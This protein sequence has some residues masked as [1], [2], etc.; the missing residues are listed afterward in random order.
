MSTLNVVK[1]ANARE[2]RFNIDVLA[3]HNNVE[4]LANQAIAFQANMAVIANADK[5]ADLCVALSGHDIEI[6]AGAAGLCEAAARPCH[7]S[8]AAIVGIAGLPS[9]LAAVQAGNDVALANKE[10]L[11]CA[12]DLLKAEALKSGA[13]IL[14]MDSEHS[15][16]FQVLQDRGD[17]EKLTLTASGG[18]FLDTPLDQ[19]AT[20]S[21]SEAMAHPRWSMGQKISIDSATMMNKALEIMEAAFLF[22]KKADEIDVVIHPQSIIHSLVHYQDGSVLAQLGEP[23]MQSPIAYALSWPD[24]RLHTDVKRLDLSVLGQLDF[25]PV[26]PIKFPAIDLAKQALQAG[27]AMPL[28]LNCANEVAVSAFIAGQCRFM[29]ISLIVE[30]TLAAYAGLETRA[31]SPNSLEDVLKL[32]ETGRQIAKKFLI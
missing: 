8:I 31:V 1:S 29:D 25:Y 18:P 12:A 28:I 32:I 26:D 4:A 13:H 19:F 3:A 30:K 24:K 20:I 17:V 2:T 7:R 5:Y 27:G 15:A 9:T 16:I 10:S 11:I 22:D 14:P 23:D 21:V 6:A